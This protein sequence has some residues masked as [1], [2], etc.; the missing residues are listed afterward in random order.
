[1][2]E[3]QPT[4][5]DMPCCLRPSR[6][7]PW[8]GHDPRGGRLGTS[9]AASRSHWLVFCSPSVLWAQQVGLASGD[10]CKYAEEEGKKLLRKRGP[11][12][13]AH[14]HGRSV[15]TLGQPWWCHDQ[16]LTEHYG[17]NKAVNKAHYRMKPGGHRLSAQTGGASSGIPILVL[18]VQCSTSEEK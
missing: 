4:A 9:F 8:S 12:F 15:L 5:M 7:W 13:A 3:K 16:Q 17:I 11:P 18:A 6:R 14:R 1:M 2:P 10:A